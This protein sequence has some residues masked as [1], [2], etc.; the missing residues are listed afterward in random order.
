ML[1]DAKGIAILTVQGGFRRQR[2]GRH[3]SRH[4]EVG[5]NRWSGP[6]AIGTG[7]AGWRAQVGAAVSEFVVIRHRR[8]REGVSRGGNV[9]IG[10]DITAAIGPVGRKLGADVM[11][12]AAVYTY[13]RS[14]GPSPA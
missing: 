13:S 14:Q 10:G 9:T 1:R 11:P 8:R 7:G 6:S 5:S 12:V 2:R 4:R 3:R